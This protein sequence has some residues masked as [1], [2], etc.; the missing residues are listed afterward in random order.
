MGFARQNNAEVG[1]LISVFPEGNAEH[2]VTEKGLF[3]IVHQRLIIHHNLSLPAN[4]RGMHL[5][6]C[7]IAVQTKRFINKFKISNKLL[8]LKYKVTAD[9]A[10]QVSRLE[11]QFSRLISMDSQNEDSM[12]DAIVLFSLENK[13]GYS[14]IST[15]VN[16]LYEASTTWRQVTVIVKDEYQR[17]RFRISSSANIRAHEEGYSATVTTPSTH[18]SSSQSGLSQA[19]QKCLNCN[20][21]SHLFW[22]CIAYNDVDK[23]VHGSRMP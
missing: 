1:D 3:M 8:N 23:N 16:L 13:N 20:K 15:S 6:S 7:V 12:T 17:L 21:S 14:P 19:R 2:E 9:M 10:K 18:R 5:Y 4:M 11:G 22:E